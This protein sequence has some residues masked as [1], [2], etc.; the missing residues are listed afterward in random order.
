MGAAALHEYGQEEE[1]TWLIGWR[2]L[3]GGWVVGAGGGGMAELG[4]PPR[5]M[6]RGRWVGGA[7]GSRERGGAGWA[8]VGSAGDSRVGAGG[9]VGAG[10]GD[11]ASGA[12]GGW[13][14]AGGADGHGAHPRTRL[15]GGPR[16]YVETQKPSNDERAFVYTPALAVA[17]RFPR[18]TKGGER[19]RPRR[20]WGVWRTT[21]DPTRPAGGGLAVG[22]Q[23]AFGGRTVDIWPGTGTH[24]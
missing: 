16:D 14:V 3:V 12:R 21:H 8:G 10:G 23:G 17:E 5:V 11:G 18:G 2:R 7:G 20:G 24:G 1:G 15:A 4:A 22:G 13:G 19:R 6:R 9:S